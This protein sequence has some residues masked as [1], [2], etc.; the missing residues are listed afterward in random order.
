MTPPADY[1]RGH[2]TA[3]RRAL[4]ASTAFDDSPPEQLAFF[5]AAGAVV[6]QLATIE[7]LTLEQRRVVEPLHRALR[8]AWVLGYLFG[9]AASRTE[10]RLPGRKCRRR[11]R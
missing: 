1:F 10:A 2:T 9:I 3:L 11:H 8:D 5:E 4:E 6:H 7:A